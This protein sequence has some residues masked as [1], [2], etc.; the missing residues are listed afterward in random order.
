MNNEMNDSIFPNISFKDNY[1]EKSIN[2]YDILDFLKF[3]LGCKMEWS[4]ILNLL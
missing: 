3:S 1:S 2:L 4:K